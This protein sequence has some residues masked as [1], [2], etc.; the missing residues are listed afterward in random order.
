M[1]KL[2]AKPQHPYRLADTMLAMRDRG[3]SSPL[4]IKEKSKAPIWDRWQRYN[5]E[6]VSRELCERSASQFPDA[7]VGYAYGNDPV[8]AVDVDILDLDLAIKAESLIYK[9]IGKTPLIRVGNRPKFMMFFQRDPRLWLSGRQFGGVELYWRTGQTLM[10]G[11]HEKTLTPYKW[12]SGNSPLTHGPKDLPLV[13]PDQIN[14]LM[15]DLYAQG[16]RTKKNAP[17]AG[18]LTPEQYEER[19]RQADQTSQTNPTSS[20]I[21]ERLMA[22]P[23]AWS[24]EGNTAEVLPIL[25]RSEDPIEAAARIMASAPA[26]QRHYVMSGCVHAL[27][28]MFFSDEEIGMLRDVYCAA[29]AGEVDNRDAD[30]S[31]MLQWSRAK[32]GKSYDDETPRPKFMAALRSRGIGGVR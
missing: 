6:P 22:S 16:V 10:F 12:I 18:I 14:A 9:N 24:G 29:T 23:M 17:G 30:F 21:I 3:W 13:T 5:N 2:P 27:A 28:M 26:G 1:A 19:R 15:A 20:D 25:R 11:I 31:R 7:G 8:L 4:P 32:V